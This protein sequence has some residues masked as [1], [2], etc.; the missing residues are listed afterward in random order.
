MNVLIVN[1]YDV[2]GAAN[3]CLRLHQGLLHEGV[4]ASVLLKEK[5]KTNY[6]TYQFKPEVIKLSRWQK[7]KNKLK[8]LLNSISVSK[9]TPV[10]TKS[11]FLKDRAKELEWFSYPNSNYDITTS[12]LY[13]Q[14]DIINL[15]WVSDFL[16]YSSFFEKNTKP[17]VWTLHDMNPFTG[18]EHYSED[19]CGID[20]SGFP[21]TRTITALEQE[22][23]IR[24]IEIKQRA[25]KPIN[26]LT[27]VAP[28]KWLAEEAKKSLV[29]SSKSVLHIPY[30]LDSNIFMP[31][32]RN[33]SRSVFNIPFDKKVL[34]FVAD[35]ISSHRKGFAYLQRAF[36]QLKRD[37]VVLCA[38]GDS[39][40]TLDVGNNIIELGPIYDER[41]MSMVYSAADAFIIPSLMDN[42]P[43]TVLESLMCGT[44]VIGFPVGGIP[45]MIYNGQ[46]GLISKDISV[47]S[48]LES[49]NLFFEMDGTFDRA[50][51]RDEAVKDY[52]LS[53][54]ANRY[55]NLFKSLLQ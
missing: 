12:L 1:T 50:K 49:L 30:G 22:I 48:L 15:H 21:I 28:S 5:R 7:L 34:V 36:Q 19:Y 9:H 55:V 42:L 37:D 11:A 24:N 18:G 39:N 31:R 45:D 47:S 41:L 46:N 14:A 33:Y 10:L 52:N 43:N 17:V 26:N 16:D 29:F 32:D 4:D 38:I 40:D 25:L 27:I 20:D 51:I 23:F 54:Q 2:G 6:N 44:P 8:S 13:Q 53:V 35:S 3:A